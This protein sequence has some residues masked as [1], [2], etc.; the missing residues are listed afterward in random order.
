[1]TLLQT[2]RRP[3]I[4]QIALFDLITATIGLYLVLKQVFPYRTQRFYYAW[5][6]VSLLPV[7][8]AFHYLFD[9]PTQLNYDLGLSSRPL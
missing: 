1:M 6:A 8:V 4:F 7:S 5:T 2:L 3:K 9:I